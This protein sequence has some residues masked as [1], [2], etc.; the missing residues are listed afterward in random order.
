MKTKLIV[1]IFSLLILSCHRREYTAIYNVY[2][3]NES[4]KELYLKYYRYGLVQENLT[5]K[6]IKNGECRNVFSATGR[7]S[8]STYGNLM[9]YSDSAVVT[10]EDSSKLVY[11]GYFQ[12]TGPNPKAYPNNHPRNFFGKDSIGQSVRNDWVYKLLSETKHS[13]NEELRYTFTEQDFLDA[14]NK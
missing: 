8:T 12:K 10:F 6:S 4:G 5:E 3:C 9:G 11:Y 2:I 13:R 1:L 14:K 7:G